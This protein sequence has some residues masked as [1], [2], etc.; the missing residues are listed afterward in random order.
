MASNLKQTKAGLTADLTLAGDPC[1]VYGFDIADLTL[2][3]EYQSKE[4]LAVR[5]FPAHLAAENLSLYILDPELVTQP[6]INEGCTKMGSDLRFSWR[7]SPSFSF[8]IERAS[9]GDV[10][11]DTT[12]NI[13]VFEDQFLELRTHMVPE[14]NIYGLAE[15]LHSFRL[16]DDWTQTFW[17]SYNLENDNVIDVNGHS[18]H[19][20]Y[21]ENSLQ[22]R[23]LNLSRCLCSKRPWTRLA[24]SER[25][26]YLPYHRWKFRLLLLERRQAEGCY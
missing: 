2:T 20:M 21:L 11:F 6:G 23:Q 15:S 5:I 7:T 9:S 17:S 26:C 8:K 16:G 3:V 1:N 24:A 13:L 25:S 19:P 18:T 4:R 14:Y 22:W 12:G 10:L